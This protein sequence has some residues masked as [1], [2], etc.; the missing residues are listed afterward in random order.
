VIKTG[1]S[2]IV[3]ASLAL[4]ISACSS[5]ESGPSSE[6]SSEPKGQTK[7]DK[8][9]EAASATLI[10]AAPSPAPDDLG[11]GDDVKLF[12]SPAGAMK[13]IMTVEPQIIGFGEYHKLV[14]SAKVQSALRRFADEMLDVVG[15][16]TA[17]L[18]LETWSV[19]PSCGA[20]GKAVTKQVEATI[21]RPK[22]VENEMQT[23][24]RKSQEYGI[25]GHVLKFT[26]K[27]YGAL[28]N[29][30]KNA[31]G[32]KGALNAEKL[33]E[34]VSMKLGEAGLLA[35]KANKSDKMVLLYGGATHNNLFP[36]PGLEAWSYAQALA[37]QSEASFVEVD[38]YVPE[39]V[40]GD[41][42]LSQEA[43]YPLLKEARKDQVILIRRDVSSYILVMRKD[44]A[45]LVEG[46]KD[47]QDGDEQND[48]TGKDDG[49]SNP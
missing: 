18:V 17:H 32:G 48:E 6:P 30:N 20:K 41:K 35:W 8:D 29:K 42:L 47:G 33:L 15:P 21:Q 7:A 16:Q 13:S 23:L 1:T 3:A 2:T 4:L 31:P 27:E 12:A 46:E 36:Y 40:E 38:L 5:K 19:D 22:E 49:A 11:Y 34:T 44:Y 26:C 43:W 28:L 10:D 25:R 14:S 45:E 39:L 9:L 37:E 24:M